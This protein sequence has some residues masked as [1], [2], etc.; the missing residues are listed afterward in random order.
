MPNPKRRHSHSRTRLRRSHDFLAKPHPG[1]CSV[2]G[3]PVQSHQICGF[4]GHYRGVEVIRME[5]KEEEA[6]A[7]AGGENAA[8]EEE[9]K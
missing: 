8:P 9:K 3:S 5:A 4:C 1:T 2:C 6:P 7:A